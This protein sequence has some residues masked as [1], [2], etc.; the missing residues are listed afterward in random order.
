MG[1][2]L[3]WEENAINVR[4]EGHVTDSDFAELSQNVQADSRFTELRTVLHD[5]R[6]CSGVT[7]SRRVIEMLAATD[8]AAALTNPDIRIAVVTERD[9][10]LALIKSYIDAGLSKYPVKTF[11]SIDDAQSWLQDRRYSPPV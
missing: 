9:D 4:H 1:Y 11:S 3:T 2:R 5:F 7:Y 10:V 8:F 6:E